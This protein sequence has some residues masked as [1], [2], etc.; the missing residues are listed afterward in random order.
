MLVYRIPNEGAHSDMVCRIKYI[1]PRGH[2]NTIL[3]PYEVTMQFGADFDF[4]K[5][6]FI[7]KHFFKKKDG[8]FII[9]KYN[10]G[11]GKF[12]TEKRY[13]QYVR[14]VLRDPKFKNLYKE[15][16]E[17]YSMF[18]DDEN[19][20]IASLSKDEKIQV[21]FE[22]GHLKSLEEF[23]KLPI[24]LQNTKE[25]RD[26]KIVDLYM[27]LL[28]HRNM[29]KS[30]ITPS[31]PGEISQFYDKY[32]MKLNN[33][34]DN[35]FSYR[36]Q[37]EIKDLFHSISFLKGVMALHVTS[38]SF[39]TNGDVRLNTP[40]KLFRNGQVVSYDNLSKVMSDN[41]NKIVEEVSS[42]MAAVLDA[43]KTPDLLPALGITNESA[44]YWALLVRSGLGIELASAITSQK[45]VKEHFKAL[46]NSNKELK[47]EGYKPHNINKTL[48]FYKQK[49][50]QVYDKIVKE[51]PDSKFANSNYDMPTFINDHSALDEKNL[52][53]FVA[54][55]N[56]FIEYLKDDSSISDSE[57][58]RFFRTQI[59]AL[60]VIK[61]LEK[62]VDEAREM[63][64][65]FSS[66]KE[67][68][69]N[70]E[71]IN[72]ILQLVE[73]IDNEDTPALIGKESLVNNPLIKSYI[74]TYKESFNIISS[75][76]MF[77]SDTFNEIKNNI[78]LSIKGTND[79]LKI[80]TEHRELLNNFIR[81]FLDS[82]TSFKDV[83]NGTNPITEKEYMYE[84]ER[85]LLSVDNPNK[86][87]TYTYK[88]L[89]NRTLS[90][91]E[92]IA[93]RN[94]GVLSQ[95]K[96]DSISK[97]DKKYLNLKANRLELAEKELF[98]GSL[99]SL[100]QSPKYKTLAENI[101]KY[102]FKT[103]GFYTGLN[104]FYSMIHPEVA[105][106]LGIQ[107][108]RNALK[109][110]ID[111]LD[112]FLNDERLFDKIKDQAVRNYPKKF[113]K[114][115]DNNKGLTFT[116]TKEG[117]LILNNDDKNPRLNEILI[118]K[119][120]DKIPVQYLR[121]KNSDNLVKLFRLNPSKSNDELYL[122]E[123]V[124][125]L[126]YEGLFVEIDPFSDL[127]KSE[128][129][130]NNYQAYTPKNLIKKV[131]KNGQFVE[132]SEDVTS[133]SNVE[134]LK[135]ENGTEVK[136]P[137]DITDSDFNDFVDKAAIDISNKTSNPFA[138]S[139]NDLTADTPLNDEN[140]DEDLQESENLPTFE[141]SFNEQERNTIIKN[142]SIKFGIS[143]QEVIDIINSEIAKKPI[144]AINK[145]KECYL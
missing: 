49:Y 19:F 55:E 29:L 38:H 78:A 131:F 35:Y 12:A 4:D 114:V 82:A 33:N 10:A 91:T 30:M 111:N 98:I 16:A 142:M 119:G 85:I 28:R 59:E 68:G 5:T 73:K 62:A 97:S 67:V 60:R 76:F 143:S 31:G 13:E 63:N 115:F 24:A 106:G 3:M 127:E 39:F 18:A 84:M 107:D 15:Y 8:S 79:L 52:L 135:K 11:E 41:G 92:K 141:N 71:N 2:R 121:F 46:S 65:I 113:T 108:E 37:S 83:Y 103:N 132:E 32:N 89:G 137:F 125:M 120:E 88:L 100:Y 117:E 105:V 45:G 118:S 57:R 25:A 54:N 58:L 133:E 116:E 145:L 50:A 109:A 69:P 144:D 48:D 126:G 26:N 138:I 66:N 72:Q 51:N 34:F 81:S 44:N 21:L 22:N 93:L 139:D 17:H 77:A 94:T 64:N 6:F 122:Y 101:I 96:V 75:H 7:Y 36:G 43:V 123:P 53:S 112:K 27:G 42:M 124:S 47:E 130:A 110:N 95:L 129:P 20:K 56:N 87:D 1:L 23:E 99:L 104:G 102:T 61:G 128:I 86:P 74:D 40:V 90:S 80:K 14:N 136:N 140:T 9:P 70:F 134:S